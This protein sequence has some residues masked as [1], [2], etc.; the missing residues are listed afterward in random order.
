MRD[1][2]GGAKGADSSPEGGWT[3]KIGDILTGN[4]GGNDGKWRCSNIF[5]ELKIFEI[6]QSC[7][8]VVSPEIFLWF[9]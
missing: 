3:N 2:F 4:A 1:V 6:T 9:A 8:L 7:C 5:A